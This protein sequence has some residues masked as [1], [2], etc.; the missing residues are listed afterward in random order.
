MKVPRVVLFFCLSVFSI[1]V[2]ASSDL[3]DGES[4]E[5]FAR[6]EH[7]TLVLTSKKRLLAYGRNEEGQLGIG[8][9]L[10]RR[11]PVLVNL[12]LKW[13]EWITDFQ[14]GKYHSVVLTSLGRVFVFGLNNTGQLGLKRFHYLDSPLPIELDVELSYGERIQKIDVAGFY[15]KIVSSFGREILFG[16]EQAYMHVKQFS[17]VLN[18]L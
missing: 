18:I 5:R 13:N 10:N 11:L 1:N 7:H 8:D 6:G 3:D 2:F 16:G 12:N 14:T 9:Y 4:L 17:D 15:T